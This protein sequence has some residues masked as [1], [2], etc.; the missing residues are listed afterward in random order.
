MRILVIGAAGMLGRKLVDR[1]AAEGQVGGREIGAIDLFD[2]VLP[3][4][5]VG[6][7]VPVFAS[8]GNIADAEAVTRLVSRRPDLIFHLAAIVSGEAE[9]NFELGYNVNLHGTLRL[10]E[11]IWAVGEG[12][13]PRVV[14][15]SSLAVYGA[16]LPEVIEDNQQLTPLTSYGAQKAIGELLLSDYSRRGI[17]DGI[18]LRLPTICV[19]P[20]RPNKAASGFFS[21][22]IREPLNGEEAILPVDEDA[23]HWF[24][25][26]RAAIGFLLHAARLDTRQLGANRSLSLPGVAARVGEQI[27]ALER[28]AGARVA[29]RIRRVP[30][31]TIRAIIAGWPRAFNPARAVALGFRA[32]RD[33]EEIIRTHIADERGGDFVN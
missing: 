2:V 18:G 20:G 9:A 19:R 3:V 21:S 26:P 29:S 22:I 7:A 24:A 30:D 23:R 14:F 13:K 31:P 10:F 28:I 4:A 27:A 15:T 16:P 5:P 32:E 33:F 17:L 1:L 8:A 12:Y 6:N 25:S 11:A